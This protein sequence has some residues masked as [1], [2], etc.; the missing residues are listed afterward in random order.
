MKTKIIVNLLDVDIQIVPDEMASIFNLLTLLGTNA[1]SKLAVNRKNLTDEG[2]A[3]LQDYS[4]RIK[5]L[6]IDLETNSDIPIVRKN[7]LN[8]FQQYV[9]PYD[10][11][12]FNIN[13]LG[14]NFSSILNCQ[15]IGLRSLFLTHD[16][17][18]DGNIK[19][20]EFNIDNNK[21]ISLPLKKYTEK[22]NNLPEETDDFVYIV[23]IETFKKYSH[24][25]KD[26]L[27]PNII[28]LNNGTFDFN[29]ILKIGSF[30]YS[31]DFQGSVGKSIIELQK[32]QMVE[33]ID[34]VHNKNQDLFDPDN[35]DD[36]GNADWEYIK[37]RF[38]GDEELDT[39]AFKCRKRQIME[40][41]NYRPYG[42]NNNNNFND[43]ISKY[44][45]E[46]VKRNM[47]EMQTKMGLYKMIMDQMNNKNGNSGGEVNETN[48]LNM[49]RMF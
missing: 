2:F 42:N 46:M 16:L 21:P 49:P 36:D 20:K 43:N 33:L 18:E 31:A 19:I 48:Q 23:D 37:E 44:Y 4:R 47:L 27:T 6:E 5:K 34:L 25:R 11:S 40:M 41:K 13:I 3:S 22:T 45:E 9:R 14:E 15:S 12:N 39:I 1:D 8:R 26:I 35:E 30:L 10:L 7:E 29:K 32:S 24:T 28:P 17:Q 38:L